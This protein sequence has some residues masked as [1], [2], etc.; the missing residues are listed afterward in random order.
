MN[1]SVQGPH[2]R[3]E[4]PTAPP[5]LGNPRRLL[6][7]WTVATIAPWGAADVEEAGTLLVGSEEAETLTSRTAV[8]LG[9]LLP[10]QANPASPES[11]Y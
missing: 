8:P 6:D 9:V 1:V 3:P 7:Q 4:G 5:G 10:G 11:A 2:T